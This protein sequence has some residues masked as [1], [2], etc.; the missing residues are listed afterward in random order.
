MKRNW[1][2]IEELYLGNYLFF[3]LADN[4]VTDLGISYLAQYSWPSLKILSL[5]KIYNK[6]AHNKLGNQAIKYLI[7]GEWLKLKSLWLSFNHI[8]S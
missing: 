5:S 3:I 1:N 4:E 2:S 8:G 7:E 6:L